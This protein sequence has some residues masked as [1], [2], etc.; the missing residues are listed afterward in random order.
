M[1]SLDDS[2]RF[3]Q[4]YSLVWWIK[5]LS[6]NGKTGL[7]FRNY[8]IHNSFIELPFDT[9]PTLLGAIRHEYTRGA[10]HPKHCT[11]S[12]LSPGDV[13]PLI[14]RPPSWPS[15]H[16]SPTSV[17]PF[18]QRTYTSTWVWIFPWSSGQTDR[19]STMLVPVIANSLQVQPPYARPGFLGI[20]PNGI[21]LKSEFS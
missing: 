4:E 7:I 11:V 9:E 15:T 5:P 12:W 14:N 20:H 18:L 21:L 10:L 16:N 19:H 1:L 8:V 13:S 2:H 3:R 17:T 6:V